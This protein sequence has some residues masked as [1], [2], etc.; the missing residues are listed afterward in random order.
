MKKRI[1]TILLG[2]VMVL[3]VI[4]VMTG[5]GGEN[6]YDRYGRARVIMGLWPSEY[7]EMRSEGITALFEER[8]EAFE[9]AHPQYVIVPRPFTY[10]SGAIAAQAIAGEIPTIFQTFFT[11]PNM[12][13][14]N[15]WVRPITAQLNQLGWTEHMHPMLK[16]GLSSGG[17]V[18][19]V[20]RDGYALG[21]FTNMYMLWQAG[22][23]ERESGGDRR[24]ILYDENDNPLYP[25]SFDQLRT[26]SDAVRDGF[27]SGSSG[28][29]IL[30]NNSQG[31]WQFNNIVWNFGLESFQYQA[32][33]N[34]R[35]R[36]NAPESVAAL[37]WIRTM[38]AEN[39]I[40]GTWYDYSHWPHHINSN[41]SAM[42]FVGSDA[43][44][45][46]RELGGVAAIPNEYIAFL[47]MPAQSGVSARTLVGG[48]PF[49][50]ANNATDSQVLGALKFLEFM[51]LAPVDTPVARQNIRD[52]LTL[53]RNN[54]M[55]IMPS[56]IPPWINAE[57][58]DMLREMEDEFVNINE[59]YFRSFVNRLGGMMKM[60]E[61]FAAQT[62]YSTLDI[63]IREVIRNPSGSNPQ[64]L[65]NTAN[66]NFLPHF[67]NAT[68]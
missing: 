38:R 49:M 42:A 8:R 53:A 68:R 60:E 36:L 20:P 26:T 5:C 45:N 22:I 63:A 28:I 18:W 65:L 10:S 30:S 41:A 54:G 9:A 39:L 32:G 61:P 52:G 19:G 51:G 50:F 25:T 66:T 64:A 62:M 23:I 15:R 27:G 59:R 35:V 56:F 3:S 55:P 29:T 21:M 46:P 37:E 17:D 33:G 7:D 2:F 34:W 6:P 57:F 40:S 14:A 1:L 24:F 48:V 11:E 4:P 31:G 16:E 43:I 58:V 67:N 13:I 12:L 47:P 44:A